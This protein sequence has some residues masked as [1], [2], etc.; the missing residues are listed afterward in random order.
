MTS[1]YQPPTRGRRIAGR[2][3]AWTSVATI[4]VLAVAGVALAAPTLTAASN[5]TPSADPSASGKAQPEGKKSAKGDRPKKGKGHGQLPRLG[6]AVHGEAVVR[7]KDGT[8][9][10]VY[11]QRGEV[12][13]VSATSITLKSTDGFTS[14][15][16]LTAETKVVKNRDGAKITDVRV[17]D[18]A[19]VVAV[20]SGDG[21]DARGIVVRNKGEHP[22]KDD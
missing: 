15:Y 7:G 19:G 4:G 3:A 21:K 16:A 13:A 22:K 9:L 8:Y 10:T 14:T 5:P 20:K 6:K 2:I 12:T 11:T 18:L 1:N 17:G